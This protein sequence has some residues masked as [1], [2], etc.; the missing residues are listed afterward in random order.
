MQRP[1]FYQATLV[2]HSSPWKALLTPVR[3][4]HELDNNGEKSAGEKGKRLFQKMFVAVVYLPLTLCDSMDCSPLGSPVLCCLQEFAQTHVYIKSVM[5]SNHLILCCL[6]LLLPAIFPNI[7]VF[8]NDPAFHISRS[9]YWGFS[10]SI[11]P[12]NEYS[13]L[14]SFRTDWFVWMSPRKNVPAPWLVCHV[15]LRVWEGALW[16]SKRSSANLGGGVGVKM[17]LFLELRGDCWVEG[18]PALVLLLKRQRRE[19]RRQICCLPS[20]AW[21]CLRTFENHPLGFMQSAQ[22]FWF[23]HNGPSPLTFSHKFSSWVFPGPVS[24]LFPYSPLSPHL[25]FSS[26]SAKLFL[27]AKLLSC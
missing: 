6:F 14:I 26:C 8:S 1:H 24:L 18:W 21:G 22:M 15:G 13:G 16:T 25:I 12:S 3:A 19:W 4:G 10:F 20:C 5:P 17:V 27:S 9:K 23:R 2:T 11:S 7:R